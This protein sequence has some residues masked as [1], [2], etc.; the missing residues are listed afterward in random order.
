MNPTRY[1]S[2]FREIIVITD[3]TSISGEWLLVQYLIESRLRAGGR[4]DDDETKILSRRTILA[5]IR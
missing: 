2:A 1:A 3:T 5:V 4:V